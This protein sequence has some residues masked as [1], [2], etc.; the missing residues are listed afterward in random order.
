M[1]IS[2]PWET[3]ADRDAS[4]SAVQKLREKGGAVAGAATVNVE[5]YEAAFVDLKVAAAV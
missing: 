1:V 2:T 5:P 3:A 4:N